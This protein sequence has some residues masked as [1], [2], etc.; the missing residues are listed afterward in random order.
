MLDIRVFNDLLLYSP[1]EHYWDK[2]GLLVWYNL[3]SFK[4]KHVSHGIRI[5]FHKYQRYPFACRAGW[6]EKWNPCHAA[7]RVSWILVWVNTTHKTAW[8]WPRGLLFP[9]RKLLKMD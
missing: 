6:T 5:W 8:F 3:A 1:K 2:A 9:P 7:A 4:G